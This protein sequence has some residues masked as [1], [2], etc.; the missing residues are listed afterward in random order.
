MNL[1][2]AVQ[3][4]V[5]VGGG[6]RLHRLATEEGEACL[7]AA[8]LDVATVEEDRVNRSGR[9]EIAEVEGVTRGGG[10]TWQSLQRGSASV[11]ADYLNGEICLLGRLHGFPTPVND[12]LRRRANAAAAAGLPPGSVTEAELLAELP[13]ELGRT[14]D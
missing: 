7:A 12:L 2:N 8:G 1:G 11:E 4:L 10:S 14:G 6:E 3:A 13:A 5:G 9:L